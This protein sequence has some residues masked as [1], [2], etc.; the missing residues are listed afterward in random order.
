VTFSKRSIALVV[1]QRRALALVPLRRAVRLI[2]IVERTVLI[3]LNGP[4]DVVG[5]EKIQLAVVVIVKPH[6][7]CGK[8]R[9]G[10]SRLGGHVGKLAIAQIAE[11]MVG[12]D[13]SDVDIDVAVVVI[14]A[15][16]AAEPVHFHR[17]AGLPRH[18]GKGS[19]SIVVIERGEGFARLVPRP[20]H[21]IDQQNVLPAVV[22]VIEK[23]HAATHGFRKILFSES[24]AVVFEMNACLGG[25]VREHDGPEGREGFVAASPAMDA[26]R[27][28]GR[29]EQALACR[30]NSTAG[31]LDCFCC[32]SGQERAQQQERSNRQQTIR[33]SARC[34]SLLR[35]RMSLSPKDHCATVSFAA[36]ARRESSQISTSM[37]VGPTMKSA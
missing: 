8:S 3:G 34:D 35:K 23:A 18:I 22:V 12:A 10:H 27:M 11:K 13:R 31:S 5:H 24:A 36:F 19:V 1:K 15:N 20:V 2:L 4:V 17:E 21:G 29:W 6:G 28:R 14:V 7:A 33:R 9:I 16:G 26:G 30:R 25:H 37:A 32:N